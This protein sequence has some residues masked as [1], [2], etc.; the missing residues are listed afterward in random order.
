MRRAARVD[1]NQASIVKDL[2]T[3]GA[4]VQHLHTIGEG[5]PDILVGWRRRNYLFEVKDPGKIPSKRVLTKDEEIWHA[6]WRGQINTIET[7]DDALAI[8]LR[9]DV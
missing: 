7:F 3:Y 1:G 5:C 2:R 9:E 4:T 6:E 8:I